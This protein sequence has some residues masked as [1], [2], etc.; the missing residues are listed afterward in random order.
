M[1]QVTGTRTGNMYRCTRCEQ[2]VEH[3][4]APHN[5]PKVKAA[6]IAVKPEPKVRTA[7]SALVERKKAAILATDT[8]GALTKQGRLCTMPVMR[9]EHVDRWI[10]Y[11]QVK[12]APYIGI[13][14]P[15]H[16][17]KA[18]GI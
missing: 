2:T 5:C 12:I 13:F 16:A 14:C 11:Q 15:Q 1:L 10:D 9:Q 18:A 4:F 7:W 3:P 6:V 17:Q 8:C